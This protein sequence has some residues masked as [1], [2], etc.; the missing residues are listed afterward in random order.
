MKGKVNVLRSPDGGT[1]EIHISCRAFF[2]APAFLPQ[3]ITAKLGEVGLG[4]SSP[5]ENSSQRQE[6][7][8]KKTVTHYK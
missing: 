3:K 2:S 7:K 4:A 8:G 5:F 6:A 1:E